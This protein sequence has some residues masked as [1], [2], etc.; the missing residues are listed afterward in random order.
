MPDIHPVVRS[1]LFLAAMAL[2]AGS[3]CM[4]PIAFH[5]GLPAWTPEA[6]G[7]EWRI[8]YQHLSAFDADSF[9]FLGLRFASPDVSASYLTAGV[10]VG[11][12]R[13]PVAAE[14]GL[15]SVITAGGGDFSLLAGPAIGIGY[16]DPKLNVMFRPSI[17]LL[18]IYGN[19]VDGG[20][21]QLSSWGQV[22]MLVGTGYRARGV[23][24]AAGGRAS[25]FG[26]GPLAVVGVNLRPVEFRAELSYMLPISGMA[27]GKALTVGLTAA[28]PT[29][30]EPKPRSDL[31]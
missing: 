5:D 31:W 19:H 2:L 18:D 26:A 22:S 21:V 11:D 17:Y 27:T 29:K 24:F 20:G 30:P 23:N 9:E 12:R 8:G 16:S 4:P 6:K 3:A 15:T 1:A 7:I 13:G 28:A 10:R 14:V 25:P